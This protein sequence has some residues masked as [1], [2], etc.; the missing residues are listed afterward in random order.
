MKAE[1]TARA[2]AIWDSIPR[3]MQDKLLANVWCGRCKGETTI[4]DF[5]GH[6]ERGDVVLRGSCAKCGS[7]VVRVIE[8]E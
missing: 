3:H 8:G 4:V 5:N 7:E 1:F 6:V 2:K